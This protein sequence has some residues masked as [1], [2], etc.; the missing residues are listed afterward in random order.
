MKV[1]LNMFVPIFIFGFVFNFILT[2]ILIKYSYKLGLIDYPDRR[3]MHVDSM[4]IVGG[5][6]I[7]VTV[8]IAS[9]ILLYLR[10]PQIYFSDQEIF[11]LSLI[12]I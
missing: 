8:F 3:K 2:K 6:S 5:L 1:D 4:P 11:I 9:L 10:I 7:F 12:H